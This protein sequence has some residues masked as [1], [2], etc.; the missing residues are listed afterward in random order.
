LGIRVQRQQKYIYLGNNKDIGKIRSTLDLIFKEVE[1]MIEVHFEG[2]IY[3]L[4]FGY[5][6]KMEGYTNSSSDIPKLYAIALNGEV[7]ENAT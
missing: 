4:N 7:G 1:K 6:T 3:E 2:C 5:D